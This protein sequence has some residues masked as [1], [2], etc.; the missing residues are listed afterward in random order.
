VGPPLPQG[1]ARNRSSSH[2][3][4][5]LAAGRSRFWSGEIA[6]VLLLVDSQGFRKAI[7]GWGRGSSATS[8]WEPTS[9]FFHPAPGPPPTSL[10]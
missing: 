3:G 6:P 1:G 9:S 8:G 5:P 2:P 4:A 7:G 10:W